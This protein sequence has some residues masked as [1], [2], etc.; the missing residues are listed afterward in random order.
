[1]SSFNIQAGGKYRNRCD[2]V[3]PAYADA[4]WRDVDDM[5]RTARIS[6]WQP[7]FRDSDTGITSRIGMQCA[8]S[9]P[10]IWPIIR[11]PHDLHILMQKTTE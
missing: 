4:I 8:G 6:N 10:S 3:S 2:D 11:K 7:G 5:Y 9:L 1:M